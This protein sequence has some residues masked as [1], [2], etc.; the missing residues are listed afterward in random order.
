M[1]AAVKRDHSQS[2]INH[3]IA[4]H[5]A[6][7]YRNAFI[8]EL[9]GDLMSVIHTAV[10]SIPNRNAHQQEIL[11]EHEAILRAL[12]SRDFDGASERMRL[13]IVGAGETLFC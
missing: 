12:S 8:A 10:P 7:A 9:L 5:L 3:D 4:F 6:I 13:H 2:F 11:R 1:R